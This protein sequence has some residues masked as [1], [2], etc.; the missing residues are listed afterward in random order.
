MLN[1][2]TNICLRY[3]KLKLNQAQSADNFCYFFIFIAREK[4]T[5][6]Q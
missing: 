4:N 6:N 2:Q 5:G 1:K 3:K